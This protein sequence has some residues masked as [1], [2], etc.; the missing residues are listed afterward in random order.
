MRATRKIL[1]PFGLMMCAAVVAG[2][3]MAPAPAAAA[4]IKYVVNDVPVTSYDIQRRAAFL[5]LQNRKGNL[6]AL[7]EEEMVDQALKTA[8]IKRLRI[9]I[10]NDQVNNSYERFAQGNKLSIKQ[11]DQIMAQSGVTSAHF[12]EFIRTQMAWGQA[13]Q[14]RGGAASG[15]LSEQEIVKRM[16]QNGGQKPSATEYMLQ[17]VIFVVPQAERGAI[18]GKRKREAESLR[19]R[20]AGCENTRQ[21]AKG[22][23]DVT[24]KDLG[25]YLAMQL[26]PEWA[27]Q[28]KATRAGNATQVRETPRGVEFIG[29]CSSREV[30]DD[31]VAQMVFQAESAG[32]S[33]ASDADKK[34]LA[35]L[36]EKARIVKR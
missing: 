29:V 35:E 28:I 11:L 5:K 20:F 10:G 18:L 30:S 34:V 32:S 9:S 21:F 8:E 13:M 16:M 3:A 6:S 12:K 26:P 24:V 23:L 33:E 15:R 2:P 19:T 4:E 17:Q 14:A 1:L 22:L 36:R 25:R 27:E 7:A 31:R